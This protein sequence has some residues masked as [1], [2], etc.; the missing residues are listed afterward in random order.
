MLSSVASRLSLAI[1]SAAGPLVQACGASALP[2]LEQAPAGTLSISTV[3]ERVGPPSEAPRELLKDLFVTG[4]A[5][6]VAR[7][8]PPCKG[9]TPCKPC[10][11]EVH[12][13]ADAP[14]GASIPVKWAQGNVPLQQGRRYVLQGRILPRGTESGIFGE[15]YFEPSKVYRLEAKP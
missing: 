10:W 3:I 13:F 7:P 15:W 9:P 11:A 14:E 8:C 6:R 1:L 2:V 4:L 12:D 5:L